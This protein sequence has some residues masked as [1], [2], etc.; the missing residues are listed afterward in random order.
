MHYLELIKLQQGQS[1]VSIILNFVSP[2][3]EEITQSSDQVEMRLISQFINGISGLLQK[4][5]KYF[6]DT[7][8]LTSFV[9]PATVVFPV[10]LILYLNDSDS[11][12]VSLGSS[13]S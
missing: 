1:F 3:A 11:A 4:L 7:A 8:I 5:V 13:L 12:I 6:N 9:F 10:I 2:V